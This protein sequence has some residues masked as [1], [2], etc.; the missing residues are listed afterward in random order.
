MTPERISELRRE[1]V[2]F[3][4]SD[5]AFSEDVIVECLN[6]IEWLQKQSVLARTECNGEIS[7][8]LPGHDLARK[9]LII[10]Y[11]LK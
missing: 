8:G 4:E 6:D 5:D 10:L 3:S 11:V 1:V 7:K 9:V 2:Q